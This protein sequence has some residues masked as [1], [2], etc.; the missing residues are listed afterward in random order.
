M[1]YFK[2][3]QNRHNSLKKND[4]NLFFVWATDDDDII[5]DRFDILDIDE[6][7]LFDEFKKDLIV[8]NLNFQ[9][10]VYMDLFLDEFMKIFDLFWDF[11]F[12]SS[13]FYVKILHFFS[14]W[15]TEAIRVSF[16]DFLL[17]TKL[18]KDEKQIRIDYDKYQRKINRKRMN[19]DR[20]RLANFWKILEGEG[21]RSKNKEKN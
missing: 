12:R 7:E 2:N 13:N 11:E 1:N 15:H 5:T 10:I 17:K 6:D 9:T 18:L 19:R 20:K 8:S 16:Y 21:Y 14:V 4:I 3:L